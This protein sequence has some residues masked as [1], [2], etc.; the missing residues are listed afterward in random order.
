MELMKGGGGEA[1]EAPSPADSA[2]PVTAPMAS[3]QP[4]E[5]AQAQAM[6]SISL[7]LDLLEKALSPF[8]S[9]TPEGKAVLAA[10]T[11]LTRQFGEK[12]EKAKPMVN[13]E[14]MHMMST[15]PQGGGATQEMKSMMGGGA[16][17]PSPAGAP[18]PMP[19]AA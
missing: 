14:L 6:V 3:P 12:R 13:A 11:G 4:Q 15:L 5:G 17:A 10:L 19:M 9:E 2:A 1:A 18:A 8:G 16:A 7:A